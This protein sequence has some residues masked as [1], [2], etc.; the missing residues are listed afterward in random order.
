MLQRKKPPKT[1][2]KPHPNPKKQPNN[3]NLFKY[4]NNIFLNMKSNQYTFTTILLP[5]F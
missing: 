4:F 1:Q 3:V 2:H 5:L